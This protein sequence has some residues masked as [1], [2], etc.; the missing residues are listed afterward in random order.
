MILSVIRNANV[1]FGGFNEL[2][3]EGGFELW[4]FSIELD[5]FKVLV[6]FK[7]IEFFLLE[8]FKGILDRNFGCMFN[9]NVVLFVSV[10]WAFHKFKI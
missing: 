3:P 8:L 5:I 7:L 4:A 6:E 9:K 1:F 2:L 10:C